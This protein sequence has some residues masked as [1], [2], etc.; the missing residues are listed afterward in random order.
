MTQTIPL[1]A[2]AIEVTQNDFLAFPNKTNLIF[3]GVSFSPN[4]AFE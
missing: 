4:A 2:V 1:N 3:R